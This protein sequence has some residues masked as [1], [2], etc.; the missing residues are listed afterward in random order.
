MCP[1]KITVRAAS[2]SFVGPDDSATVLPELPRQTMQ[3]DEKFQLID[4]AGEPLKNMRVELA[5]PD[6]TKMLVVTDGEGKIPLQQSFNADR[7]KFKVVG[8]VRGGG[9]Q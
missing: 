4:D 3:F 1:G 7:L 6:G 2:K 9:G 5:K 8:R